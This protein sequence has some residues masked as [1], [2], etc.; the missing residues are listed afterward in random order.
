MN[1][2]RSLVICVGIFLEHIFL[3][4]EPAASSVGTA[5]MLE[6]WYTSDLGLVLQNLR[7]V[8]DPLETKSS[9]L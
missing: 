1:D 3:N 9:F 8:S 7:P 6:V 5:I 4:N 2:A